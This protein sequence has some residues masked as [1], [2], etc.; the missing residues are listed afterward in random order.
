[1]RTRKY[2]V[3]YTFEDGHESVRVLES[4]LNLKGT[5][6]TLDRELRINKIY[7]PE[8]GWPE[9]IKVEEYRNG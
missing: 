7:D 6:E 5:Q 3:T 4:A 8:P 1:V 2:K 9:T